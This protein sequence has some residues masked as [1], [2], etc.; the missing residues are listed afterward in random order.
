MSLKTH[1]KTDDSGYSVCNKKAKSKQLTFDVEKVTCEHCKSTKVWQDDMSIK[2]RERV[3][4]SGELGEGKFETIAER[5]FCPYGAM[6]KTTMVNSINCRECKYNK[7]FDKHKTKIVCSYKYDNKKEE[8]DEF[9]MMVSNLDSTEEKT[10]L[11]KDKEKYNLSDEH[12]E[13]L[14]KVDYEVVESFNYCEGCVFDTTKITCSDIR[15]NGEYIDCGDKSSDYNI[16]FKQI[17]KKEEPKM[18][19]DE[20][21]DLTIE[22]FD[23]FVSC[24]TLHINTNVTSRIFD[25]N[26]TM[27]WVKPP[28]YK[29]EDVAF[30]KSKQ[31]SSHYQNGMETIEKIDSV[32]SHLDGKITNKEAYALG[33]FIKYIDRLGLKDTVEK[34]SYKASDYASMFKN[35]K[36]IKDLK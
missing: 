10:Q 13:I 29:P 19:I 8:R 35:D 20:S 28:E 7:A 4:D 17:H 3:A 21:E 16:I 30:N 31:E 24:D 15:T 23:D 36:W 12:V 34:D 9:Q 1:Y 18:W 11:E 27:I 22:N 33:N 14:S 26:G 25:E 5:G 32:L 6:N 2:E